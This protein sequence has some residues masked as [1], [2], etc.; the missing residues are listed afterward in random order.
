MSPTHLL[1]PMLHRKS[2]TCASTLSFVNDGHPKFTPLDLLVMRVLS[3]RLQGSQHMPPF[4]KEVF[5]LIYKV[6]MPGFSVTS[7]ILLAVA[8]ND[9]SVYTRIYD[10]LDAKLRGPMIQHCPSMSP[11]FRF[12]ALYLRSPSFSAKSMIL[13]KLEAT[14]LS[15]LAPMVARFYKNHSWHDM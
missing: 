8:I 13:S 9:E 4:S 3:F 14:P 11:T 7:M 5:M 6:N 1:K 2:P 15:R 12:M 10:D